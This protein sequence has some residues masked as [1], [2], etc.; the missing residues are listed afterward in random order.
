MNP[1][2]TSHIIKLISHR[3]NIY[4]QLKNDPA[5]S[6][7]K[8]TYNLFRNRTT[9]E[10]RKAKREYFKTYFESNVNNMKKT[11]K[12]IK[13]II[14]LNSKS[15]DQITKLNQNGK[16]IDNDYEMAN[17]FDNYFTNIGPQLDKNILQSQRQN[18][19]TI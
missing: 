6:T 14:N 8:K 9:R 13:D 18:S 12:G 2:I 19:H 7:L 17:I 15:G 10:I 1:W 4:A 11:L 5:N 3:N 16:I